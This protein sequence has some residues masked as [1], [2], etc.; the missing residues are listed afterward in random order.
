[1]L[2]QDK[3]KIVEIHCYEVRRVLVDYMEGDLTPEL[4]ARVDRHLQGC[5]HCTA[6]FDGVRN[7]ARLLGSKDAIELPEGF[8]QR[9]SKRFLSRVQ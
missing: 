7:V 5:N 3:R 9:L 6:V 8:S 1:M 2:V 4:R